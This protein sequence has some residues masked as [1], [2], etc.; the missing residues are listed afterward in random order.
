MARKP[1]ALKAGRAAV[2]RR[3]VNRRREITIERLMREYRKTDKPSDELRRNIQQAVDKAAG[4]NVLHPR[5]ASRIK[6][7]IAKSATQATK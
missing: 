1:S 5:K 3:Q 6:S 7:R 2:R 4:R